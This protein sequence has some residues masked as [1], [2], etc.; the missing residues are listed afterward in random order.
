MEIC[1]NSVLLLNFRRACGLASIVDGE[2]HTGLR[3]DVATKQSATLSAE[4]NDV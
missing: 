2:L 4:Q 1:A 3:V